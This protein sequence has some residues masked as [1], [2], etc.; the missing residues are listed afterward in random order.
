M[1]RTA[2]PRKDFYRYAAG[3]WIRTH[4]VPADK[5]RWGAFNELR[6]WNMLLLKGIAEKCASDMAAPVGSEV[7]LVGDFYQS[8]MNTKQIDALRF[9]P[10]DDLWK[11]VEDISSAEE[12]AASIPKLHPQGLFPL[13]GSFSKADDKNS[14][15]YAFFFGQGGLSLPDREYYLSPGF[16][17]LKKQF[18]AHVTRMFGMKALPA[19]QAAESAKAVLAIETALAKSSRTRTELRD[20][21]KNYNRMDVSALE[22]RYRSLAPTSYLEGVGVKDAS[23]VVVGQPE[24]F[25]SLATL[26]NKRSLSEWKAYLHWQLITSFAPF[27]HQKVEL[28]DFDFFQRK[29]QGQVKQEPR[30]KRAVQAVDGMIGEALGKQ[31]VEKHFPEESR[32]RAAV[33][34]DDLRQVFRKRLANLPW[35]TQAT[36]EAAL[37]KFE[38]FTAKIGYPEKFRDYSA[39]EIRPDD[40]VGNVRRSRAFEFHRLTARVGGP[41]DREEWFMTPPTVNAY[42]EETTNEIV[43]PAGILQPSFFDSGMDDAVNYGAIGVVIGHEITHGFDDQGRRYDAEGNLRDWWTP[44]DA[45]AFGKKARAVV[46]AY[47][48]QVVVKGKHVNGELTLGENIADLGGVSIAYEALQRRLKQEPEKRRLI[49]GMTPEQRFFVSHAQTW[50]QTIRPRQ[51]ELLLT[52]DPH[53]PGRQRGTLPVVNHPAFDEAFPPGPREITE[54]KI[55]VW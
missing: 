14:S 28:E 19:K 10:V 23:Y 12:L 32:R 3:G 11:M 36:R 44:A 13:F 34:V 45:K 52:V 42:F 24:F 20:R 25:D 53:S 26:V 54:P 50:R 18:E 55:G 4:P 1:D 9:T 29:V 51:A 33:L 7:R 30:W 47:S 8:I 37:A 15:V 27:L 43:F 22:S 38:K 16:S 35:M 17:T 48:A 2:N 46:K 31:Y 6:E 40:L 5:S 41:V 21:E 39:L 49:D